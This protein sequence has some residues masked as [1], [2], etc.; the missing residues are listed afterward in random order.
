L[1]RSN[2]SNPFSAAIHRLHDQSRHRKREAWDDWNG[3][4][5]TLGGHAYLHC[6]SNNYLD[7]AQHPTVK[8]AAVEAI[9]KYGMGSGGARL[10]GGTSPVH[11]ALEARLNRF[12][13]L[14]S[15]LL[16]NTGY[17]ANLG[18]VSVLGKLLGPVFSDHANHASVVDGLQQLQ[19]QARGA[20]PAAFHRYRHRDMSHLRV[21]LETHGRQGGLVLT[22]TLFSMD[23][24][25]APLEELFA[26]QKQYGFWL[27][28]DEAHSTLC[29]PDLWRDHLSGNER[30]FVMGTFGKAFGGF[31]AYVCGPQDGIDFLIQ[32][33]RPFIFS[34]S[35]PPSI[36]AAADAA[37]TLSEQEPHRA[38]RLREIAAML[39]AELEADGFDLS[40][41]ESH[42]V[43]VVFGEDAKAM[44]ASRL[45][46]DQGIY[47]PAIRPP[48]VAEGKA[49][50]RL[51]LT[52]AFDAQDIRHLVQ[53]LNGARRSLQ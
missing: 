34:T 45:L 33:C 24:D 46:R 2:P 10:L 27:L 18:L 20:A 21:L 1:N 53:A 14:G 39:R 51:S 47:A 9:R 5:V 36:L 12:R 52:S 35:L 42:I 3:K 16:F 40:G 50:I 25:F 32:F 31:G 7:L 38:A 6:A 49:R 15:S 19:G 22:E 23:G 28:F 41:S 13:P 43:P 26:L 17:M 29:F 4:T 8:A 48:T 11:D 37:W 44:Q 30:V